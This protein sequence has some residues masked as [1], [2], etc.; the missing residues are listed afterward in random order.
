VSAEP[1]V[2]TSGCSLIRAAAPPA[3]HEALATEYESLAKD[4]DAL[5]ALH[6]QLAKGQ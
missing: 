3:D 1:P 6:R 4:A 2:I 5:A